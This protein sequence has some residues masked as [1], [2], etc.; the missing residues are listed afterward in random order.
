MKHT[1]L[2]ILKAENEKLAAQVKIL[3]KEIDQLKAALSHAQWQT[4]SNSFAHG[5]I[6]SAAD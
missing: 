4:R 2:K 6:I 3:Q 5:M 1:K